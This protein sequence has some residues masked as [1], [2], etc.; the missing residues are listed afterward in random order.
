MKQ[1]FPTS[2]NNISCCNANEKPISQQQYED[3]VE[4]TN[5]AEQEAADAKRCVS[6]HIEDLQ[7]HV[8]TS[9]ITA[10]TANVESI[11]V[12]CDLTVNGTASVG[13][14]LIVDRRVISDCTITCT[15]TASDYLGDKV[16]VNQVN[17]TDV[18][19]E[20]V[21]VDHLTAEHALV[22]CAN[23]CNLT[24][25]NAH[26]NG[27]TEVEGSVHL[28]N[29]D[30]TLDEDSTLNVCGTYNVES[31]RANEF[32]APEIN[33]TNVDVSDTLNTK[34]ITHTYCQ[35]S[36]Q[37]NDKKYLLLPIFTNGLYLLEGKNDTNSRKWSV[38]ILNSI[39][40]IEFR[41]SEEKLGYLR[42]IKYGIDASGAAVV[43]VHI[44]QLGENIQ[45]FYQS[46]STDNMDA[47]TWY[48]QDQLSS[49]SIEDEKSGI[50][51]RQLAGTY[52]NNIIFTDKL[53][54]KCLEMDSLFM[55]CV[56]VYRKLFLTCD[57][58][59]SG[60]IVAPVITS[61]T[62]DQYLANKDICGYV[63]PT[64]V[65]SAE[66]VALNSD[67][68]MGSG[69][70]CTTLLASCTVA[71]YDGTVK[72][73]WTD[74][75]CWNYPI[76]NLGHN[77]VVH[78]NATVNCDLTV[79][80]GL[81]APHIIDSIDKTEESNTLTNMTPGNAFSVTWTPPEEWTDD[82][83]TR[84]TIHCGAW[85]D[86]TTCWSGDYGVYS[87]KSGCPYDYICTSNGLLEVD[88]ACY[89]L[90]RYD[91]T[92]RSVYYYDA[93]DTAIG[94]VEWNH[95]S[96]VD[97]FINTICCYGF[98]DPTVKGLGPWKRATVVDDNQR[99][100]EL[101]VYNE[102][103]NWQTTVDPDTG[104]T[105]LGAG[106]KVL[107]YDEH[108]NALNPVD[109][110]TLTNLDVN[111]L[112]VYNDAQVD[113]NLTVDGDLYVKGVTHTVEEETVST[114]SDMLVLRQNNPTALAS[115]EV[116]GMLVN[117]ALGNDKAIAVVTDSTGTLRIGE[118]VGS[119]TGE[120]E[121]LYYKAG[122]WY[123]DIQEE[124]EVHPVGELSSWSAKTFTENGST[125]YTDP[126]FLEYNYTGLSPVL[127]RDETSNMRNNSL[128]IW[129]GT[130]WEA[131]TIDQPVAD[132]TLHYG[133][134]ETE[135]GP[136]NKYYWKKDSGVYH[137]ATIAEY[138]LAEDDIPENSVVVIDEIED[139]TISED[140]E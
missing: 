124:N 14:D 71:K 53:H 13:K 111:D 110:L 43:Q 8:G 28:T 11:G 92:Y 70:S 82:N 59:I 69:V 33:T 98:K 113:H 6:E 38:E 37:I 75:C 102:D 125:K 107:V 26:L 134:V 95:R 46:I 2:N 100:D 5:I 47:P 115:G 86:Y 89:V 55:D 22:G 7:N 129:N 97:R 49:V 117:N 41:W 91:T 18:C 122:H 63:T 15:I 31:F 76:N 99:Y 128:L 10:N 56:G 72:N 25:G 121:V 24:S 104:E 52:I 123:T 40:N 68:I 1:I 140:V 139:Y 138:E 96:T 118:P 106:G 126:K 103:F 12:A 101:A 54:V 80:H 94:C 62:A 87:H 32:T 85:Y 119:L 57:Y 116:S 84:P 109:T 9:S 58:D 36:V 137:F 3:L 17:T 16:Y 50:I 20:N 30:L 35:T 120:W 78:G 74:C 19:S 42:D 66:T 135:T 114:S 77:T 73:G 67:G 21:L 51:I 132:T 45:V 112:R 27:T 23:L 93:S 127:G 131:N 29:T 44:D 108:A 34:F 48:D 88:K 83:F 81:D 90:D 133:E 64:W 65:S 130:T 79:C 60:D 105:I 61:G 4:R 39:N 136:V